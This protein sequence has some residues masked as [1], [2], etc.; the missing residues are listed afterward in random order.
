MFSFCSC[1]GACFVP[2]G[3]WSDVRQ[4]VQ[5]TDRLDHNKHVKSVH[6]HPVEVQEPA[7]ASSLPPRLSAP[8]PF[9]RWAFVPMVVF[10]IHFFLARGVLFSERSPFLLGS[11]IVGIFSSPAAR[12][13]LPVGE[14]LLHNCSARMPWFVEHEV[15]QEQGVFQ[16]P[17]HLSVCGSKSNPIERP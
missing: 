12:E 2:K 6:T 1:P 7:C 9:L 8:F 17:G 11:I 10:S 14:L 3:M 13:G 15:F 5:T 4:C 16:E